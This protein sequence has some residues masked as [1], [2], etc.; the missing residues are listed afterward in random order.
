MNAVA[1]GPRRVEIIRTVLSAGYGG[2]GEALFEP[3]H[4]RFEAFAEVA[5]VREVTVELRDAGLQRSD[6]PTDGAEVREV[7]ADDGPSTP[8]PVPLPSGWRPLI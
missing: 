2:C 7:W 1:V 8:F 5:L 3:V 6:D 4:A